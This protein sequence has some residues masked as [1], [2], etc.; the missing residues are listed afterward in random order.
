MGNELFGIDIAGIVADQIGPG[1]LDVLL[2]EPVRGARDFSNLTGGR[3]PLPAATF[4]ARGFW[5][6]FT[7]TPPPGVTIL[8]DDRKAVILGDTIEAGAVPERGWHVTIEGVKLVIVKKLNRDPAA[9]VYTFQCRDR[10][11]PG[12]QP[13][14]P[15]QSAP[16][17][18]A[19]SDFANGVYVIDGVQKTLAQMWAETGLSLGGETFDATSIAPGVGLRVTSAGTVVRQIMPT[20]TPEL[21]A[22]LGDEFSFLIDYS[23]VT[24]GSNSPGVS[25]Y[26]GN[27]PNLATA[28]SFD[29]RLETPDDGIARRV[30]SDQNSYFAVEDQEPGSH[31][32]AG[33]FGN[34][35]LL[36]SANGEPA[37]ELL[38][39]LPVD[40]SK[41]AVG[42]RAGGPGG[43]G[44]C[45]ATISRIAFGPLQ[46]AAALQALSA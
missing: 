13:A 15:A 36:F 39:P 12:A 43:A 7:G 28:H 11:G 45:T 44:S 25:V 31:R 18:S 24:S 26:A 40:S 3:A 2:T 4:K 41:V 23:L 1:V 10:L 33:S 14:S 17:P 19:L 5:E 22:A 37:V 42:V 8:P 21:F 6:D 34:G 30:I 20:A 27:L 35:A 29:A 32:V 9:A 38:N 16:F 46:G